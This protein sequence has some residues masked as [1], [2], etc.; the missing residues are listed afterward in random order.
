MKSPQ[1]GTTDRISLQLAGVA[2][3]DALKC[4]EES[5]VKRQVRSTLETDGVIYPPTHQVPFHHF[6]CWLKSAYGIRCG[7]AERRYQPV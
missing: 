3:L 1:N 6:K 7:S 5:T 2:K 4:F